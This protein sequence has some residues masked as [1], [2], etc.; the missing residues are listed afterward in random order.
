MIVLA[1]RVDVTYTVP[2]RQ[3]KS[4][5]PKFAK[6]QR[7]IHLEEF[8]PRIRMLLEHLETW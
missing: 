4:R 3:V 7:D 2:Q 6:G 8:D 5:L 1:K